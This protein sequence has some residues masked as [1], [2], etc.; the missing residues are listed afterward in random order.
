MKLPPLTKATSVVYK[1]EISKIT[2]TSKGEWGTLSA[3]GVLCHLRAAVQASLGEIEVPSNSSFIKRLPFLRK[4]ILLFP[5][6]KNI[7]A[8]EVLSPAP[9]G[10]FEQDRELLFQTL[11]RFAARGDAEPNAKFDHLVFGPMPLREWANMHAIHTAHHLK[12]F[13]IR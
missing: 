13:G 9:S 10:T 11:D 6:P 7:K 4:F 3:H 8:P 1:Q 12:Q 2:Q 5:L